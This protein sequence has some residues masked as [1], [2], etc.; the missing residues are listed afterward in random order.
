MPSKGTTIRN[1]R[2]EAELWDPAKA[3]ALAN[4]E[5]LSGAVIRPALRA[6]LNEEAPV[7]QTPAELAMSRVLSP[8]TA[9]ATVCQISG[10]Y[11]MEVG[12]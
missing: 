2:V 7:D 10:K 8:E 6:Y 4:G 3:K 11:K 12:E 5:N 1:V 9:L